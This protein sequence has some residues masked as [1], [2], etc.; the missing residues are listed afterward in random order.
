MIQY[1]RDIEISRWPRGLAR[2]AIAAPAAS[3]ASHFRA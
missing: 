3:P 1:D 2:G